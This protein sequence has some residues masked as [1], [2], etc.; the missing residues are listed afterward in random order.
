MQTI[1]T[2]AKRFSEHV[3]THMAADFEHIL[4]RIGGGD[5]RCKIEK[6]IET[7]GNPR[8]FFEVSISPRR[9]FELR[10]RFTSAGWLHME[11]AATRDGAALFFGLADILL[12]VGV[13]IW[14]GVTPQNMRTLADGLETT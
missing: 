4:N 2:V 7:D 14:E 11:V 8:M 9:P 13:D 12:Q 1:L 3:P 10:M 5:A 6:I